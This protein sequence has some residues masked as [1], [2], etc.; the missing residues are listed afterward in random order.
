M[1]KEI[2]AFL[3]T[4]GGIIYLGVDDD[5]IG[6]GVDNL[7]G[8]LRKVFDIITNQIYPSAKNCVKVEVVYDDGKV[9]I[10]IRINKGFAP[11]YCVKE[12]GFSSN[13]CHIR[14][15]KTYKSMTEKM[16]EERCVKGICDYDVM[17]Q[18]PTYYGDISFK[19]LKFL[20]MENGYSIE[21]ESYEKNLKLKTNNG[22]YNFLAELLSD[23]NMIPLIFAKFKG[24]NKTTYSERTDYGF[25]CLVVAYEKL[26]GRLELENICKTITS[27]RPRKDIYLYDMDSVNEALVNA[28]VYNDYRIASPL[29]S[30]FDD[31]LEII[32]HGGLSLGLTKEEF[33]KGISKPINEPLANIFKRLGLI[34]QK[35]Y[36]VQTI[37]KKYGIEAFNIREYYINV[38]IPFNKEV[39]A[40]HGS[41]S[42]EISGINDGL[43]K[44]EEQILLL[45][46]N[47][48]ELSTEKLSNQL[49]IPFRSV[50][51]YIS[52]L[53]A[54][55]IVKRIGS[56]KTGYWEILRF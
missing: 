53:K 49:N 11:I 42:G 20:F 15:E 2:E 35:G 9:L 51:R 24:L 50:Q 55:G 37:V 48:P 32:S 26:K 17:I 3:N 13:G 23:N 1:T 21:E 16:I 34:K 52:N 54:K 7:D 25:Q 4:D 30:F 36:G 27:E 19:Q 22:E 39:I 29:V 44:K 5:G 56:K 28:I 14:A 31:R 40:N 46:K 47:N 18:T 12:Y 43:N 10:K 33:F 41:L 6:V 45:L 8:T 38:I